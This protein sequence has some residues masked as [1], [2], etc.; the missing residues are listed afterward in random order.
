MLLFFFLT[1]LTGRLQGWRVSGIFRE[2][3]LIP[4]FVLELFYLGVQTST[5]CGC[6]WFIPYAPWIKRAYFLVLLVPILVHKLYR[7]AILGAGAVAAGTILNR[8]VISANGGKMPVFA[9]LSL[10]TGYF[11]PNFAAVGDTLHMIGSASTRLAF[12]ADYIDLGYCVLSI[13]D[14]LVH[15]F[16]FI[17]ILA[18]V[19]AVCS[20]REPRQKIKTEG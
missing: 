3:S 11:T 1:L 9:T 13:G 7:P 2:K 6:Y 14:V 18:T 12:L 8:I 19:H 17:I 10:R 15:S 16:T 5:F 20:R 4:Y